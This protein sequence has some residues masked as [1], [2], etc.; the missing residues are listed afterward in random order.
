MKTLVVSTIA[1]ATVVILSG[2]T[3]A[4]N[5]ACVWTG[6][7]WA[8]GDGV[9][10]NQHFSREQG[11]DMVITPVQTVVMPAKEPRRYAPPPGAY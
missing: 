1:A 7:D 6:Y 10:M 9:V 11:P 4:A 5:K 3:Q 2:T 8:C